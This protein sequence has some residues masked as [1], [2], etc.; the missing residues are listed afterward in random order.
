MKLHIHLTPLECEK[1]IMLIMPLYDSR[2]E[3]SETAR[4]P[5]CHKSTISRKLK[6]DTFSGLYSSLPGVKSS[7]TQAK[8]WRQGIL[9]RVRG[10]FYFKRRSLKQISIRLKKRELRS[11]LVTRRSTAAST[12]MPLSAA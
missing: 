12:G 8:A 1:K 9:K 3:N 7:V 6:Q 11:P 5:K 4:R 10:L 2:K